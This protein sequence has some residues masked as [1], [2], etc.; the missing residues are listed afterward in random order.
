MSSASNNSFTTSLPMWTTYFFSC[1]IALARNLNTML[2]RSGEN[3]HP[4]LVLE[5]RGK[6]FSIS[7]LSMRLAEV[8]KRWPLL[9]WDMFPLKPFCWKFF[10]IDILW[11]LSHAFYASVEMI[12]WFLSYLLLIWCI[13]FI[14]LWIK[15]HYWVP[16]INPT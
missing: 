4:C 12:T 14:D 1:L 11:I 8:W 3:R 10:I 5:F 13:T 7:P 15:N 2:K 9:F 16:G 6:A